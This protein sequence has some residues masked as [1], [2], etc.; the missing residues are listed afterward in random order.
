MYVLLSYSTYCITSPVN[1]FLGF[2][3][4]RRIQPSSVRLDEH[5]CN[6]WSI[7]RRA[8][9]AHEF[10]KNYSMKLNP[11]I[12]F[13]RNSRQLLPNIFRQKG[14]RNFFSASFNCNGARRFICIPIDWICK[15]SVY[16]RT[17]LTA[18]S[19]SLQSSMFSYQ[20][21]SGSLHWKM[22]MK[23]YPEQYCWNNRRNGE[24]RAIMPVKF[25]AQTGP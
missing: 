3:Q 4:Q 8:I 2:W 12:D 16:R 18:R 24:S 17:P 7:F 13:C 23:F 19:L 1:F 20:G 15:R 21:C 5:R 22:I 14:V 10:S 25:L 11:A 9:T 6:L